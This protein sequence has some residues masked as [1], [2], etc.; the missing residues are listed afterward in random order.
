MSLLTLMRHA[1]ASFGAQ[2]YDALSPLGRQQAAATGAWLRDRRQSPSVAWHGPR[3]RHA[4]TASAVLA[5]AAIAIKPS[6]TPALDEFCEGD[7][8]LKAAQIVSGQ[9]MSGP[10]AP[11]QSE[12]LRWYHEAIMAWSRGDLEIPGRQGFR[13]FRIAVRTWLEHLI[14]QT[15]L[16]SGRCELAVTSAGVISAVVCDLLD[17]PDAQ[18]NVLLRVIQ[19]ASIT[20][21]VF[22]KGRSGLQSFNGIGHLPHALVS[23]M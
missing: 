3:Q 10:Q 4:D 23:V 22:S 1:Q 18:W 20:E 5:A 6:M 2:T 15:G 14:G 13:Q 17:L 19:N 11:P 7:E 8:V 21:V 16:A 12:Q 9:P